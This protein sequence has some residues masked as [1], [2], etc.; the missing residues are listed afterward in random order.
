[1]NLELLRAVSNPPGL[2]GF[3]DEVQKVAIESL[4]ASCD[5][6]WSDRLNNV[7][8]L[9]RAVDPAL[10]NGRPRRVVVAAHADEIGMVVKHVDEHG[11]IR[12]HPVGGLHAPSLI[13]QQVLIHGRETIRGVI[14]PNTFEQREIPELTDILIDVARPRE[15][16]QRLVALG[17]PITFAQEVSMMNDEVVTGRTFDDR[18]GTYCLL[19][20]MR[21][22]GPT[23]VDVYGVSTVQEEVGVRGA[24][25]VGYALEP[26]I[27][28]AI[29]GS[30]TQHAYSTAHQWWCHLGEG[31]GVYVID[32]RTIGDRRLLDFLFRVGADHGIPVQKDVGGGT[33]ASE[34][35]R[36][37]RG[38]LATTI[39]APVRYMHSTVQLCHTRDIE[40]T[41]ALL[42]TFLEHA[43]E[44]P[45][46]P[47]WAVGAADGP[48]RG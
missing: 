13:S 10:E 26:D 42:T 29:D 18:I 47:D 24:P 35:Q 40:A 25:V 31:A 38:S 28:L 34:M 3:E 11:Y 32:N 44:L 9:K 45:L 14:A 27:A 20:A 1:M 39:G 33:D 30:L 48:A 6:V 5:E 41:V 46:R 22:V 19:E 4:T 16:V 2:S 12:F 23:R 7:I 17:D 37:R 8:G 43:H 21:R 36:N 15:E